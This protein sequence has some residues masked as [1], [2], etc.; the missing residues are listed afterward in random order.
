MIKKTPKNPI[1]TLKKNQ[2]KK[3]PFL[4]KILISIAIFWGLALFYFIVL[5]SSSPRSIDYITKQIQ[6][7]LDQNFSQK[8]LIS[9]T[10]IK[11]T[12][13][14]SFVISATDISIN[15]EDSEINE[16][17]QAI[18]INKS[19][20]IPKIE[21][22][23]SLLDFVLF[24][25]NPAKIKIFKP[26][27]IIDNT[28]NLSQIVRTSP[29]QSVPQNFENEQLFVMVNFLSSLRK[30]KNPIENLEIID[31]KIL[32]QTLK[33]HSTL[34]IKTAKISS[35]INGKSLDISSQGEIFFSK[36]K[37]DFKIDSNCKLSASDGLSCDINLFNFLPNSIVEFNEIFKDLNNIDTAVNG[38]LKLLIN[39][40]K[41][42]NLLT[43]NLRADKGSFEFKNYFQDKI[44]FR[45]MKI[46]GE[47]NATSKILNFNSI[48]AD[49]VSDIANQ[50]E[51]LNPKLNL[52][53]IISALENNQKFFDFDINL[54]NVLTDEINR[55]WP[56]SLSQNGIRDW[57]I[58]HINKGSIDESSA[59]FSLIQHDNEVQ[60]KNIDAKLNFN[61]LSL[62][63]DKNFPTIKN[64]IGSAEFNLN[65]M[66][67]NLQSGNVLD[68]KINS[69]QISIDDFNIPINILKIEGNVF[70]NAV[71]GLKHAN[72]GQEFHQILEKNLKG[73][74]E[75]FI[76]IYLPLK[77]NLQLKDVYIKVDS[78]LNNIEN[79]FLKG[80]IVS[81]TKKDFESNIF[82]I[83]I[84][85]TEA[86]IEQNL[87]K[88]SKKISEKIALKFL[89]DVSNSKI[90]SFKNIYYGDPEKQLQKNVNQI[91]GSL[92]ISAESGDIIKINL[93][94]QNINKNNYKISYKKDINKSLINLD[95]HGKY[96][97]LSEIFMEKF[98][99]NNEKNLIKNYKINCAI[100]NLVLA[101]KKTL[102]AVN[103]NLDCRNNICLDGFLKATIYKNKKNSNNINLKI[104]KNL[105]EKNSNN[106]SL[107]E[108]QVQ[109]IGYVLEAL[110]ISKL[111]GNGDVKIKILQ[112]IIDN[113]LVLDG[114][115][116][117][118][119]DITIFENEA[120]K[121]LTKNDL[122]SKIKDKIFSSEK[123]TFSSMIIDFSY[124]DSLLTLKSLI[125]NNFKIGITAKGN[126]NFADDSI[127]I[128]G[129]IIPGYIVNSLFGLGNIPLLGGVIS[130]ILTG[131]EGGGIFSIRY[132]YVKKPADKEGQ[133]STNKVSAFV[134]SSISSLFE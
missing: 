59:K 84:D 47:F 10:L 53:L 104:S 36:N 48:E 30:N 121:K 110:N 63:Y 99:K 55:F 11:F 112:N 26:E 5:V 128:K 35:K 105:N 93:T 119:S 31:G 38:S 12:R 19:L 118:S 25:F 57:V 111:V 56:I 102:S 1:K 4:Y 95:I 29:D 33:I 90:L 7:N 97:D 85:L 79:E 65:S 88:I 2:H 9:K 100:N 32:F 66:K 69:A 46:I 98:E 130:G 18:T 134:P 73:N 41:S 13:Y 24:K 78:V 17:N 6:K 89:L 77:E 92:D 107:I 61:N 81:S 114:T 127:Q 3:L 60:L 23:F 80:K 39:K 68:S 96:L 28:N 20:N 71:D 122:L 116:N 15:Y 87:L 16:L 133:F 126:I 101:N 8:I 62:S 34:I 125:A 94:N 49:L 37:S 109:D 64:A 113:K 44:D 67:I 129:M 40:S 50:T 52:S 27:I 72:N 103:L 76:N 108:G 106:Q 123:T 74:A 22:E 131:G 83:D 75:N 117:A 120:V 115:I 70:G 14:G 91:F 82:N 43:F 58:N 86:K 45:N 21:A 42:L 124:Q 54:K 132:E 51:I